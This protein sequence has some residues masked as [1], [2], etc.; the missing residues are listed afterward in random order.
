MDYE[1]FAN[2]RNDLGPP[3]PSRLPCPSAHGDDVPVF[4]DG[5]PEG[6]TVSGPRVV[7]DAWSEPAGRR[8]LAFLAVRKF[9]PDV[10]DRR[11]DPFP[12]AGAGHDLRW[13]CSASQD[14]ID[15]WRTSGDDAFATTDAVT[16]WLAGTFMTLGGAL[17]ASFPSSRV[18]E[19]V[20][21]C[22][23]ERTSDTL[24]DRTVEV[25]R[26]RVRGDT[27]ETI[28]ADHDVTRERVRQVEKAAV[29]RLTE[30][31]AALRSTRHPILLACSAHANRLASRVL[32][33]ASHDEVR[34][35][36]D[37]RQRWLRQ[38]LTTDEAD[39]LGSLLLVAEKADLDL[40]TILDPF[41]RLGWPFQGGRTVSRWRDR[42]VTA[43]ADG[44]TAIAGEGGR[45][46]A[47][48]A[49]EGP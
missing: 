46:R 43:L 6:G 16:A 8:A 28:A 24:G 35:G 14:D 30:R 36:A 44:F 49:D 25:L 5:H 45:R 48:V 7:A 18:W 4:P 42:D 15:D 2:E 40:R 21:E 37:D 34:L 31:L 9:G 20:L 3:M 33:A 39:F 23:R 17:V 12:M 29:E 38:L 19:A 11:V 32:V 13:L 22:L 41:E 27:L 1:T 47:R 10:L 26:R